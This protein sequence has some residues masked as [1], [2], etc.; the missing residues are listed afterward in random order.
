ML[1]V[2]KLPKGSETES[3]LFLAAWTNYMEDDCIASIPFGWQRCT[4]P[5]ILITASGET[6]SARY[7]VIS[8]LDTS[9]GQLGASDRSRCMTRWY[10]SS[11]SEMPRQ[12]ADHCTRDAQR[13]LHIQWNKR[14]RERPRSHDCFDPSEVHLLRA[15]GHYGV[16]T[17]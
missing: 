2:S 15:T 9:I 4:I 8:L 11:K 7:V 17:H 16:E 3:Y 6:K 5:T 1:G 10:K 13:G 14:Y 12:V